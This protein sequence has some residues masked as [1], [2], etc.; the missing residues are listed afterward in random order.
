MNAILQLVVVAVVSIRN[1]CY[2]SDIKDS[3]SGSFKIVLSIA[4]L[5]IKY[6]QQIWNIIRHE[7]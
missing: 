1:G 6:K 2:S 5:K 3:S 7:P 4:A